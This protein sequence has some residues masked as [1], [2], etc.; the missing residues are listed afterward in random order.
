MRSF[1]VCLNDLVLSL[2]GGFSL[3][4]VLQSKTVMDYGL[5]AQFWKVAKFPACKGKNSA[6]C[7]KA[8]H[9]LYISWVSGTFR[10]LERVLDGNPRLGDRYIRIALT[11]SPPPPPDRPS[12]P[13]SL[14]SRPN[15]WF[16]DLLIYRDR[17]PQKIG[18]QGKS[19]V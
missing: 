19:E 18:C 6:N 7:T 17:P 10:D 3:G 5:E 12:I 1:S 11:I 4:R 13:P 15:G 16:S 2:S 14:M 8:E 9:F